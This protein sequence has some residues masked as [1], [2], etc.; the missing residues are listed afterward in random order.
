MAYP[1]LDIGGSRLTIYLEEAKNALQSLASNFIEE[2]TL[3][4]GNTKVQNV[5][6]FIS[7]SVDGAIVAGRVTMEAGAQRVIPDD[8]DAG[9]NMACIGYRVGMEIQDNAGIKGTIESMTIDADGDLVIQTSGLAG[10]IDTSVLA[11]PPTFS[12]EI[13][14]IEL[15]LLETIPDPGTVKQIR[16]VMTRGI[17]YQTT[18]LTKISTPAQ[19]VNAVVDI[20][21]AITRGLSI[22]VSPVATDKIGKDNACLLYTSPSPR[23]RQKS[24]MPSSA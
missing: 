5:H 17:N 9:F 14:K 2:A 20:P 23:D 12:Y 4:D 11:V 21:S 18:Q 15:K 10:S 8:S 22:M 1:N 7:E 19:L 16:K 3:Q 24:R 6:K 13:D